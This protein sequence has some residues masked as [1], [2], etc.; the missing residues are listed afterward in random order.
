[1]KDNTTDIGVAIGRFQIDRLHSGHLALIDHILKNHSKVIVF[2]G[3]ALGE[4][5]ED[6]ALGYA[7]REKMIKAAYPSVITMPIMDV[8]DDV[9]W[10]NNIDSKIREVFKHGTVTLYGGRESFIPH[11]TGKHKTFEIENAIEESGTLRRQQIKNEIRDSED[12]R[13]GIL[14]H[15]A[16]SYPNVFPCVDAAIVKGAGDEQEIL[17]ARKPNEKLLRF[18]GGHVDPEDESYENAVRRE[19]IEEVG[20]IELGAPEYVCS[21]RVDDWRYRSS[22][23]K[24]TTVLY[25]MQYMYGT[26]K[27]DDDIVECKWVLIKDLLD[28][29]LESQIVSEHIP[30]MKELLKTI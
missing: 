16:N 19:S 1:M 10:S 13:A 4:H 20:M 6:N 12:F 11:Y 14:Y 22:R 27:P 18:P 17:L 15:A 29:S 2:L 5:K 28:N 3:C 30:L 25:K 24:I 8:N 23:N 9:I 21:M 26:I 7:T